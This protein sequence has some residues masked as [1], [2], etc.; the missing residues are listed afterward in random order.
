MADFL[1]VVGGEVLGVGHHE[2]RARA[3]VHRVGG[4]PCV[5]RVDEVVAPPP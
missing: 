2:V 5:R 3:A 1:A 4:A